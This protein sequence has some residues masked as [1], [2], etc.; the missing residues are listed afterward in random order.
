[1]TRKVI[2]RFHQLT[3][4]AIESLSLM[5]SQMRHPIFLDG[6]K[7]TWSAG[8]CA[9]L[10]FVES[11]VKVGLHLTTDPALSGSRVDLE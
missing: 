6:T 2:L 5:R 9:P 4:E 7:T 10:C 3:L 8:S 11:S 1:M